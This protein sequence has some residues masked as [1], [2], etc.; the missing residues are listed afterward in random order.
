LG[1]SRPFL[2]YRWSAWFVLDGIA[3]YTVL[4]GAE[5]AVVRAAIMAGLV[6]I[7]ARLLGRPT[8]VPAGEGNR[9]GHPHAEVLQ[10][11]SIAGAAVLRTDE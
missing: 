9:C 2:G 11:V 8:F 6:I 1:L 4:V 5:A 3:L 7:A 10:R